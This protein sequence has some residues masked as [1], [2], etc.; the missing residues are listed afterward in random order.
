MKVVLE[1]ALKEMIEF[2]TSNISEG[3]RILAECIECCDQESVKRW[4]VTCE[5]GSLDLVDALQQLKQGDDLPL[6]EF[7]KSNFYDCI[8][9]AHRFLDKELNPEL[10]IDCSSNKI[11]FDR[12]DLV[13]TI[14]RT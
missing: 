2:F 9:N 3:P 11:R 7:V 12:D 8:P 13:K 5:V 6:R 4:C 1:L 14:G 10:V